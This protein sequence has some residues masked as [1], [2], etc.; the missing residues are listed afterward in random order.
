MS[1]PQTPQIIWEG[2]EYNDG[3][4]RRIRAQS[5]TGHDLW[6]ER[7]TLDDGDW[8]QIMGGLAIRN[9]EQAIAV[10]MAID[11]YLETPPAPT[12]A[13][14]TPSEVEAMQTLMQAANRLV[15]Y[16]RHLPSRVLSQAFSEA[17]DQVAALL[18][19]VVDGEDAIDEAETFSQ[20]VVA[21]EEPIKW[22]GKHIA[23]I[24]IDL[25]I[26]PCPVGY[27][28]SQFWRLSDELGEEI[29]LDLHSLTWLAILIPKIRQSYQQAVSRGGG[30]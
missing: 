24:E 2:D 19:G 7:L 4:M 16:C 28:D 14:Y 12:P 27:A 3:R 6:L 1:F 15:G 11:T 10:R 29:S 5:S 20:Y 17:I 8:L 25:I 22:D 21:L 30:E 26:E 13:T 23:P 18:D 9:R